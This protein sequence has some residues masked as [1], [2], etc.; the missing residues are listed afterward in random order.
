MEAG[1]AQGLIFGPTKP[2][3]MA[4]NPLRLPLN[5][6][7]NNSTSVSPEAEVL[8]IDFLLEHKPRG[9]TFARFARGKEAYLGGPA[10]SSIESKALRKKCRHRLE[11]LQRLFPRELNRLR[12]LA[13]ERVTSNL[14]VQFPSHLDSPPRSDLPTAAPDHSPQQQS[15]Q[16]SI[17]QSA[18]TLISPI[19]SPD[20]PEV[21]SPGMASQRAAGRGAGGGGAAA[22]GGRSSN[23]NTELQLDF[24]RPENN[25]HGI[26]VFRDRH[27]SH[28]GGPRVDMVK[29]RKYLLDPR[30]PLE[31]SG[32]LTTGTDGLILNGPSQPS[33]FRLNAEQFHDGEELFGNQ[34]DAAVERLA[35]SHLSDITYR[36]PAGVTCRVAPFSTTHQVYMHIDGNEEMDFG[37]TDD[38][39]PPN[40]IHY[41]IYWIEFWLSVNQP[42][43]DNKRNRTREMEALRNRFGN[44]LRL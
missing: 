19:L 22:G 18:S 32:R 23:S 5:E 40:P 13:R 12:G 14:Q 15:P 44:S 6:A 1:E 10:S 39:I 34:Q 21:I 17:H 4:H 42:D 31:T 30:D 37:H 3:N 11:Y 25:P 27:Y 8:I 35:S 7:R 16:P 24:D 2:S 33:F 9:V 41:K 36:F 28:N 43:E 38:A 26:S 29:I 20:Q